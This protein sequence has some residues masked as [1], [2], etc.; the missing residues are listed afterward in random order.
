MFRQFGFKNIVSRKRFLLSSSALILVI[1]ISGCA[2]TNLRPFADASATLRTS[3][4]SAGDLVIEPLV[5]ESIWDSDRAQY[6]DPRDEGHPA[7]EL[8]RSWAI[9]KEAMDAVLVYSA[10]LSAIS[11][12]ASQ[13]SENAA[14]LVD[15]V[16]QLVAS[17]PPISA[18]FTSAGDLLLFG[19]STAVEIKAWHDMSK[20]VESAHPA[21]EMVAD[22]LKDDFDEL[23]NLFQARMNV[24]LTDVDA[25]LRTT[26]QEI[27]DIEKERDALSQASEPSSSSNG[28]DDDLTAIVRRAVDHLARLTQFQLNQ[29]RLSRLEDQLEEKGNELHDLEEQRDLLTERRVDGLGFFDLAVKALDAWENAHADLYEALVGNRSPNLALLVARAQDLNNILDELE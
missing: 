19:L 23:R 18:V 8:A 6:I 13:R 16:Q 5:L 22:V 25:F 26:R 14:A 27:S 12:A 11:E 2:T 15:S 17:V 24:I 28:A 4:Y 10:S 1:V 20:A 9:R 29:D 7:S 21:I 3:V